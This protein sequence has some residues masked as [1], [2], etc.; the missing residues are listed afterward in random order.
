MFKKEAKGML[1]YLTFPVL[2]GL[3]VTLFLPRIYPKK[4]ISDTYV[5]REVREQS[6]S[7][8]ISSIQKFPYDASTTKKERIVSNYHKLSIG[9]TRNDALLLLG[10]PDSITEEYNKT[11]E[12]LFLGWT[13]TYYLHRHE[14]ELSNEMFDQ[15]VTLYFD[16]LGKMYRVVP[17]NIK[18]FA[19]K[20]S[21]VSVNQ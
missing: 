13:W 12:N 2:I 19:E 8:F 11:K 18:N 4:H 10:E 5:S 1:I 14:A 3:I 16:K 9:I 20:R 7:T 21:P 6:F 15:I 17:M